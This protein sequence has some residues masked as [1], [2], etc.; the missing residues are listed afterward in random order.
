MNIAMIVL[1]Y[2]AHDQ[3]NLEKIQVW[4]RLIR[5]LL[6]ISL[7]LDFQRMTLALPTRELRKGT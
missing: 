1:N 6:I 5:T 4:N 3:Y 2:V 7:E